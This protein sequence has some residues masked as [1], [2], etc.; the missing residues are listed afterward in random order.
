[1]WAQTPLALAEAVARARLAHPLLAAAQERIVAARGLRTQAGLT[2]NP[3][4]ILQHENIRS[5]AGPSPGYG[6]LTDSFAYFQQT[7]ETGGKRG[8]R[9][10]AA[11]EAVR[12]AELEHDALNRQIGWRVKQAYWAAAGAQ[13]ARGVLEETVKNFQQIIVYH[14]NRLKEGAVA[15]ADLLRVRIEGERLKIAVNGASLDAERTLVQLGREMGSEEFPPLRLTEPLETD[16]AG[17]AAVEIAAAMETRPETRIARQALEQARAGLRVERAQARPNVDVLFGFK[18]TAGFNTMLGGFQVDMPFAN[19][20]QGRIEIASAEIRVAQAQMAA[21]EAVVRAE[22]HAARAD[23]ELRRRQLTG[24]LKLLREQTAE[25]ARIA[26]AAYREGGS[27]L[28]RLLDAERVRLD[29]DLLYVK[30]L[31]EFR[32]SIAALEAA[33]GMEP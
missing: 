22:I 6:S 28:L 11:G 18:R 32:Q 33:Q 30:T 12:R 29:T 13:A 24:S 9:T 23:Y 7:L 10:D 2:F 8:L 16:G 3:R 20:N 5:Y 4:L 19:R 25:A 31:A 27:D 26:R 1:V 15:G 21:A 14:E 17:P